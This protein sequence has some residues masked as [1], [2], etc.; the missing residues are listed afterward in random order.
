M[1]GEQKNSG[2]SEM[3]PFNDL[4]ADI[5]EITGIFFRWMVKMKGGAINVSMRLPGSSIQAAKKIY[6]GPAPWLQ[7]GLSI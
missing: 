4:E 3:V 1:H 7:A 5:P 6:P 2:R